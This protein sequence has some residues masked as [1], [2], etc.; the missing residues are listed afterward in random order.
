MT[1]PTATTARIGVAVVGAGVIGH[2]HTAAVLRH[3]RLRL[4]AVVDP[5][6]AARGKL[7]ERVVGE[8]TGDPPEEFDSLTA[9]D[10]RFGEIWRRRGM[11]ADRPARRCGR[12]GVGRREARAR[13]EAGRCVPWP[14]PAP[15][16]RGHRRGPARRLSTVVS[17]HRFDPASVV[18]ARAIADGRLGHVTSAVA[19]VAWWRCRATTT[20]RRGAAPGNSTAAAR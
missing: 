7:A 20:P 13:R 11:Y 19:S 9:L 12:G 18:V 14:G 5:D 17:Q 2:N 16:P 8:W 1:E 3:P 15:R 10:G 6:A 4:A